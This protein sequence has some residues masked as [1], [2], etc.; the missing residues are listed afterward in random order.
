MSLIPT[1]HVEPRDTVPLRLDHTLHERLEQYAAF[2]KSPKHYVV[3]Q[4]LER[5]FRGDKTFIRWLAE[6]ARPRAGA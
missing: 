4:A 6:R 1:Q 2:I 5:L 3:A